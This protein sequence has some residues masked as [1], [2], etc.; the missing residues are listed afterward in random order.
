MVLSSRIVV[1][2]RIGHKLLNIC[3]MHVLAHQEL[4]N[5]FLK[6]IRNPGLLASRWN[7]YAHF[8]YIYVQL[9]PYKPI[10]A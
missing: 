10:F 7:C 1:S 5:H 3:G 9:L 2:P 8:V 4:G 6:Q